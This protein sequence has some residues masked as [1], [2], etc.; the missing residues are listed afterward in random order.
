MSE[1]T[2]YIFYESGFPYYE[3]NNNMKKWAAESMGKAEG[4]YESI[5][6]VEKGRKLL[7]VV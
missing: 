4:P 1:L 6:T 3:Q 7:P 2:D 5:Q